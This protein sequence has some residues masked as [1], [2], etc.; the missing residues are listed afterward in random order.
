MASIM[1]TVEL[2][3][4]HKGMTISPEVIRRDFPPNVNEQHRDYAQMLH[5]WIQ[6]LQL[7]LEQAG[8]FWTVCMQDYQVRILT[9]SEAINHNK[10]RFEQ[11]IKKLL[12]RHRL[13][14]GIDHS[15]LSPRDLN[16]LQHRLR[17]QGAV[18]SKIGETKSQF[19]I[20][21]TVRNTPNFLR[22]D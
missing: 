19:E 3:S 8:K 6:H 4:L 18:I 10:T 7:R 22:N 11:G 16:K 21:A 1:A 13:M 5:Y 12:K 9:D 20:R 14:L 2:D 15:Q 17:F